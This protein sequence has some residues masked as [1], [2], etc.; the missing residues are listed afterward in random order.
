MS[1]RPGT[2]L[3]PYEIVSAIGA[4]G[5]GEVYRARDTKLNRDVAIKV[6]LEHVATDPERLA[7][8]HREAQVL[9]SL[10]HPNIAHI[11]GVEDSNATHGLVMELVEG[12][13][14]AEM[15]AGSGLSASG[16][17]H[18]ATSEAQSPKPKADGLP[19]DDALN[20]A[21]QIAE[22]LEAAHEQGIIHR[23]LKP[24]N[25]K[26]RED[27]TVKVLDFGL[28]KLVDSSA[29]R[30]Q[31]AS[32]TASPTITTPAA[33]I[34]GMILGTAAYMAPEQARGKP[35]DKRAD[36]W[37]FGAVLFEMLT[38][39]PPFPGEDLSHVLARVIE[40]DPDW[41]A[42]PS[43]LS[44]A[45]AT[46]LRRC[47][48]KDPRDRM[49]DIG[50]VR[51]A[52][53]GAFDIVAPQPAP[54]LPPAAPLWW[55][56]WIAFAVS[57]MAAVALSIPA[58]RHL[59]ETPS[60]T[61]TRLNVLTPP[62]VDPLAFAL[63][64]D[65]RQLVYAGD[66]DGRQ[67]LWLRA[68]DDST[69]RVLN[70][71]DDASYPFWAPDG[72]AVGFFAG[73]KLKSF[74]LGSGTTQ[75]LA[76][77]RDGRGGT[78]NREGV[79]LFVPNLISPV[80]RVPASGGP[81]AAVTTLTTVQPSHRAPQFLP[82]GRRF[83]FA[84]TPAQPEALGVYL[85]SLDGGQPRRV[86]AADLAAA[87]APPNRLLVVRQNVL[88]ALPFDVAS[89]TVSGDPE[90]LARDVGEGAGTG[91]NAV[92]AAAAGMLAYRSGGGQLRQ[93]TWVDRN[94]HVLGPIGTP[95]RDSPSSPVLSPDGKTVALMRG[96]LASRN[97][98]IWLTDVGRGIL[99]RFT[100]DPG[101]DGNPI[102]SP[103]GGRVAFM[104]NRNGSFDLFE[105]PTDGSAEE[106]RVIASPER[107]QP[108]DWSP[109]GKSVLLNV[110]DAKTGAAGI[111][112]WTPGGGTQT[113]PVVAPSMFQVGAGQFS[114][115]GHWIAYVSDE[116]GQAE[117]YVRPFPSSSATGGASQV[118]SG[119]G[120]QPRWGH[121][122]KELFYISADSRM[123]AVPVTPGADGRGMSVGTAVPLFTTRLASGPN[124]AGGIARPAQ[125]SVAADGRFL[126]LSV[127][128]DAA[129][130]IT[131]LQNWPAAL[132]K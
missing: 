127:A 69:P 1:V 114:P 36:I 5:M 40:R 52:L 47:L 110:T 6:L 95:D 87:F 104:S 14:L 124:V 67:R 125:Y 46:C 73:G 58:V 89:G 56:P 115:D 43:A 66:S 123:T 3:G 9:A 17:G 50:D 20:I 48:V 131:I 94:G 76:D 53:T 105:K 12:Q 112:V 62:A 2:R 24:A 60:A 64:P 92:S 38:G 49:R 97:I 13:T 75:A 79:I 90:P 102:W 7:R 29:T 101:V 80:M 31:N 15:L 117:V 122:G 111:E 33:T 59:R 100:V 8:L 35:V 132:K 30:P 23:D 19:L 22:A 27:G 121:D 74:D 107:K 10:N 103:D 108:T 42:L 55:L 96:N 54:S 86:L 93:L 4:G 78:W 119:G 88:M 65:G 70:G 128:D 130:P 25:V 113:T 129:P 81:V 126:L 37:A 109:D 98:D 99:R 34:A 106:R 91:I 51:L 32:V 44:P 85:T 83:L 120:T 63:S 26:V 84:V 77:A 72:H 82:D 61:V 57:L 21:R 11:Y 39:Q 45:I 116:S 16:S 41:S 118:S 71:T 18:A 28:A 68:L